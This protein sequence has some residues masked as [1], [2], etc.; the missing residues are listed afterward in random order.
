MTVSCH[1]CGQEWPR[2]P[3][4]E[5]PCPDC[6]ARVGAWCKRPSGH[7]AMDLHVARD[8][9]AMAAGL[10]ERCP[11]AARAAVAEATSQLALGL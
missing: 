9:A 4:L 7:K 10:L 1:A 3:A 2:D 6:K 5:V 11:A 8:H